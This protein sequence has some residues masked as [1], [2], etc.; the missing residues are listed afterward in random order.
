[1]NKKEFKQWVKKTYRDFQK[2]KQAIAYSGWSDVVIVYDP[3]AVKSAIAK[4]YPQDTFD[5][6]TGVA[7]A[8]ARLKGIEIPKV[9]EEPEFKRVGNGQEYYCIGKFNTARF[10]AVYTL[11]TDHFLDKASFENNNYFHTRK[12]AEEVADK[13]NLLLKLERLHDT[14]C[15]DYVPD[16]QDNAR[17]YYVFYGTKDSTY[18]VGG[19]LAADRKPC[20]Y[21]PTTEIA[22][23]VCVILNGETKNAKSLCGAC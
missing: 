15:P 4:C 19:C 12:R 5:Y 14:Y 16:W 3:T 23:K 21:F 9:E 22:Q 13:I 7:I 10:G 2:D 17:K 18:Y 8:Y 20:V 6:D 1:M 11:E